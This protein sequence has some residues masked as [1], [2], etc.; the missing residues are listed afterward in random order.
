MPILSSAV[1]ETIFARFT[2]WGGASRKKA[3]SASLLGATYV[4][5]EF[6]AANERKKCRN[7]S[8]NEAAKSTE[9]QRRPVWC[10]KRSDGL[11]INGRHLYFQRHGKGR[12]WSDVSK[13]WDKLTRQ[14]KQPYV[15]DAKALREQNRQQKEEQMAEALTSSEEPSL[16]ALASGETFPLSASTIE[17]M[18]SSSYDLKSSSKGFESFIA[19]PVKGDALRATYR[20]LDHPSI[21]S[22]QDRSARRLA[23]RIITSVADIITYHTR[24]IYPADWEPLETDRGRSRL[25]LTLQTRPASMC[26]IKI[27]SVVMRPVFDCL[28]AVLGT[29]PDMTISSE[30]LPAAVRVVKMSHLADVAVHLATGC[31]NDDIGVK[32]NFL[33]SLT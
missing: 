3:Q 24:C 13:D 1:V 6:V 22:L 21:G 7:S 31:D 5:Q 4:L 27:C 9:A 10:C 28:C 15:D 33:T 14:G 12:P 32:V 17:D 19:S 8:N 20:R 11:E 30:E 16:W 2:Q 25:I 18:R 23:R 29:P 26:C